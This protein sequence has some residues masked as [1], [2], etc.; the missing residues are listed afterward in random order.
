[1]FGWDIGKRNVELKEIGEKIFGEWI[2][3]N[4]KDINYEQKFGKSNIPIYTSYRLSYA[5][6]PFEQ[7]IYTNIIEYISPLERIISLYNS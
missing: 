2:D 5:S 1:M 6:V 3:F 4:H 7:T